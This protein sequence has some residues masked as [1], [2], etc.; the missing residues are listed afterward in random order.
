MA[1]G[2]AEKFDPRIRAER[3]VKPGVGEVAFELPF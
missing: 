1:L 2:Q 3:E